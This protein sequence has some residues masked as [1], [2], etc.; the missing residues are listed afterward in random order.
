MR[1]KKLLLKAHTVEM[2]QDQSTAIPLH[3][4]AG[5]TYGHVNGIAGPKFNVCQPVD[6]QPPTTVSA[7]AAYGSEPLAKAIG[8]RI[9]AAGERSPASF[10]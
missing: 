1:S 2:I 7:H 3:L 4:P 10:T 8:I 6:R 5:L 9:V